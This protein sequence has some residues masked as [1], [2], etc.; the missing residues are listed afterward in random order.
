MGRWASVKVHRLKLD[1]DGRSNRWLAGLQRRWSHLRRGVRLAVVPL[2]AALLAL[3][4]VAV[5][6]VVQEAS[7]QGTGAQAMTPIFVPLTSGGP[8]LQPPVITS[9][10][11]VLK[12]TDTATRAGIPGS[13]RTVLWG[14][15]PMY[16]SP[17]VPPTSPLKDAFG[18]AA[19]PHFPLNFAAAFQF[20]AYGTTYP[21]EFPGPTLR[22]N[23]GD[24]LD[25]T[26][27]DKLQIGKLNYQ[28]PALAAEMNLHTHGLTTSPLGASDNI[29]RTMAPN[30]SSQSKV[31]ITNDDG[32]GVDWYHTHKHGYVSDQVYSG[33]A[34]M[35]QVGD[36]LDSWPQYKGKYSGEAPRSDRWHR[37]LG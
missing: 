35:L 28:L 15:A 17:L 23:P 34:G 27:I 11:G 30:T 18:T 6:G 5:R 29:Y 21:A 36:P 22:L 24:T 8:L 16:S 37:A 12:A 9:R 10:H 19:P 25:L 13:G 7:A 32:S 20:T 4:V 1:R 2:A 26:T 14:G 3:A 33:L 31:K